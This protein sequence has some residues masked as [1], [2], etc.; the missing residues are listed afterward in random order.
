MWRD[1]FQV[2]GESLKV[3]SVFSPIPRVQSGYS[4]DGSAKPEDKERILTPDASG[5]LTQDTGRDAHANS[6]VFPLMQL[7]CRVDTP[8]HINRSHLLASRPVYGYAAAEICWRNTAENVQRDLSFVRM[9]C[10]L[11]TIFWR[12]EDFV[13]VLSAVAVTNSNV[14]A[15][16]FFAGRASSELAL[17]MGEGSVSCLALHKQGLF[18]GGEDGVLRHLQV[19]SNRA[20]VKEV[21][22]VGVPISTLAFNA[23]HSKLSLGGSK[24]CVTFCFLAFHFQ[25]FPTWYKESTERAQ[26]PQGGG[27][28]FLWEGEET[29]VLV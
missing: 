21:Y 29:T 10:M 17:T 5:T 2:D 1:L 8:I 11:K 14:S 6:N 28:A 4:R 24:V 16:F 25:E 13:R 19:T 27:E 7:A 26:V 15:L 18:A 12:G 9:N 3:T 20:H 22:P 23:A